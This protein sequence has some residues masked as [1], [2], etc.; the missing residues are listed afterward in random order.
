MKKLNLRVH[1]LALKNGLKIRHLLASHEWIEW[2]RFE[3]TT[4]IFLMEGCSWAI[5]AICGFPIL[6][7]ISEQIFMLDVPTL[8]WSSKHEFR[9]SVHLLYVTDSVCGVPQPSWINKGRLPL[10]VIT[11]KSLVLKHNEKTWPS[12]AHCTV[13]PQIVR[14]ILSLYL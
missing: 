1:F 11:T 8:V 7:S 3:E 5:L 9:C 10:K 12:L 13:Q 4:C 14:N 2:T 6:V